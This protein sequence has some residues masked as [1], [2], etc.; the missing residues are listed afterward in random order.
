VILHDMNFRVDSI[1][2]VTIIEMEILTG[3]MFYCYYL[4]LYF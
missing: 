3:N 1:S 4:E 2:T